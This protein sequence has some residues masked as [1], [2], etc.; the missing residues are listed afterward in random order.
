MDLVSLAPIVLLVAA[1]YFLIIRPQRMRQRRH[2]DM[3]ASIQPGTQVMT[4]FGVMGTVAAVA[5]DELSL[6][7][8][9]GVF[10]RIIPSAVGK[11]I[12]PAPSVGGDSEAG[13]E[14]R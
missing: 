4:S 5:D 13:S 9:P 11:V 1:F 10:I 7:I 3:V 6:E 2:S 12:E 8:S 14:S